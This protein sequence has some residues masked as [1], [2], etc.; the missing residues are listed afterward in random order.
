MTDAK[1]TL[2][3]FD[4]ALE[5]LRKAV[6][7]MASLS[8]RSLE[9]VLNGLRDRNDDLCLQAIADDEEIDQLEKQIDREG[10]DLLIRYQPVA[11]D[12][13]RVVSAM[14]MSPN[15]ERIADEAVNIARRARKLNR[16]RELAE[17]QLIMKMGAH[18]LQMV[19]DSIDAFVREDIEQARAV[20]A[21]DDPLDEMNAGAVGQLLARTTED[22][23]ELRGYLNLLFVA[24]H[25][26]RIG[27]HATNIGEE[28]VY[29]VLAEDIRH[30]RT[31]DQK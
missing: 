20:V 18:A 19:R 21:R 12:L 23:E 29:A 9:N 14:K 2:T 15:L 17:V 22:P 30:Q 11:S 16:H 27:D 31:A 7:T 5:S 1:H 25:L 8:L 4:Q 24:G 13:R 28:T 26:E 3:S 10:L 6:L